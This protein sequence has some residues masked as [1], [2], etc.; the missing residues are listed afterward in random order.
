MKPER[1]YKLCHHCHDPILDRPKQAEWHG[2]NHP[3]CYAAH[4]VYLRDQERKCRE[5][6][7]DERKKPVNSDGR[8]ADK[9]RHTGK[10]C[11]QENCHRCKSRKLPV[12][13][14]YA[15]PEYYSRHNENIEGNY[16]YAA[17]GVFDE[18]EV[19]R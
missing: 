9:R 3:E 19:E 11:K 15:C 2:P 12:G 14:H 18:R 1:T 10:P 4:N 5:H 16:V 17:W 8:R 13:Y 7:L 6:Q